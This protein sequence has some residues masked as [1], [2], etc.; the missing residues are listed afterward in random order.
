MPEAAG[1]TPVSKHVLLTLD[2]ELSY[3]TV[4]TATPSIT[5]AP[6]GPKKSKLR[7]CVA[8]QLSMKKLLRT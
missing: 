4:L 5:P 2:T 7:L 1:G 3:P 6:M 8:L